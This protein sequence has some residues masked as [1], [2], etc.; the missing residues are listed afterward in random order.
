MHVPEG[1]QKVERSE[2]NTR[3]RQRPLLGETE[4]S[5]PP[6]PPIN[7]DAGETSP[8]A[9]EGAPEGVPG[10]DRLFDR[11]KPPPTR[12]SKATRG[13][14]SDAHRSKQASALC[15]HS[16]RKNPR[17]ERPRRKRGPLLWWR[18]VRR[19]W[20]PRGG[21]GQGGGGG[22]EEGPAWLAGGRCGGCSGGSSQSQ[23]GRGTKRSRSRSWKLN[24]QQVTLVGLVFSFTY[25]YE[26]AIALQQYR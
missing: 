13:V 3:A 18:G 14:G 22:T 12:T 10:H 2:Y 15:L 7:V 19:Q 8:R 25:F 16:K 5:A 9:R 6:S 11:H 4:H 21:G 23:L 26:A 1:T 24:E 17:R 20:R